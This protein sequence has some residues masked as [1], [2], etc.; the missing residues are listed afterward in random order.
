[1]EQIT[2]KERDNNLVIDFVG[3]RGMV[4]ELAGYRE[5]ILRIHEKTR[6]K[7]DPAESY[8][9]YLINVLLINNLSEMIMEQ[10]VLSDCKRIVFK[11]PSLIADGAKMELTGFLDGRG[12]IQNVFHRLIHSEQHLAGDLAVEALEG[13]WPADTA[14]PDVVGTEA[15]LR[16]QPQGVRSIKERLHDDLIAFQFVKKN[17][18]N[19]Q[20]RFILPVYVDEARLAQQGLTDIENHL[21]A[22][23]SMHYLQMLTKIHDFFIQSYQWPDPKGFRN[24]DLMVALIDLLDYQ[25]DPYPTGL[26]KSLEVGRSTTGKCAFIAGPADAFA[27]P[28][29]IMMGLQAK[30]IFGLVPRIREITRKGV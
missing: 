12:I 4:V 5:F 17:H 19:E 21:P 22:W 15:I 14:D 27:I 2:V 18:K 6:F 9:T 1:M 11:D 13:E 23:G 8:F 25:I 3:K 10:A 24:D 30:D 16:F 29:E 26:Q 7:G 28:Q 20:G